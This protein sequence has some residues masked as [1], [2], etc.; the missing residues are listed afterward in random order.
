MIKKF[1]NNSLKYLSIIQ[2]MFIK[3]DNINLNDY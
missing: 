1:A 3:L 2:E